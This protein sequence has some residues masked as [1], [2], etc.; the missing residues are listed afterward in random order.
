MESLEM[1]CFEIISS[2]GSARSC[3]IEA[4]QE[5]KVGNFDKANELMQEGKRLFQDGHKFHKVLIEK[6]AS[7]EKVET[8]LLLI[9]S[10]DQMM[11]A[12]VLEIMAREIIELY[13]NK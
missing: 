8:R 5:A 6:E 2:V 3:Y 12:E 9:H 13:K 10:E 4:I 1:T 7:G 11:S